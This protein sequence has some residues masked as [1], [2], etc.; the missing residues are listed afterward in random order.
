MHSVAQDSQFEAKYVGME[1]T[2]RAWKVPT[3]FSSLFY[4]NR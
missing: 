2:L 1:A 4:I 3:V